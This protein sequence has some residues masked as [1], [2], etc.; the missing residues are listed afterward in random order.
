MMIDMLYFA[1]YIYVVAVLAQ[2]VRTSWAAHEADVT[3]A[4]AQDKSAFKVLTLAY[5]AITAAILF[6]SLI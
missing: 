4:V 6:F 5:F 3:R 1:A 2:V